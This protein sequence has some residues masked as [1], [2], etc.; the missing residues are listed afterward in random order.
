M[1]TA[2]SSRTAV[3]PERPAFFR[4]TMGGVEVALLAIY[5]VITLYPLIW[6]MISAFKTNADFA[7][8]FAL[9]AEWH[10]DNLRTA[11]TV[12]K[13]GTAMTNSVIVTSI[14]LALT[15]VLGALA[16][17]VLSR[18][19]FRFKALLMGF[20]LLGML[21]PI[22][23]TLVPLFILMN[24]VHLLNT[25]PAL[26]LPYFSFQ[27]PTAIFIATAYM[28]TFPKDIEE[29]AFVDGLGYWGIFR[30]IIL[31]LAS[32]ALAT[33]AILSVLRFWNEFSFALVFINKAALKTVPLSLSVFANGY[34]TD[35]KLTMA[36]MA[37]SV[38]PTILIYLFFSEKI[39]KGMTAGAVKG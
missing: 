26:I 19:Q 33:V 14:T 20:F 18:F 30:K 21:I 36:A 32:P 35:Y 17:Y 7:R 11:W 31:P 15:L 12:S 39:M 5:S 6:L 13:M 2:L 38:I 27:L 24:K 3:G 10:W 25:Y 9:P 23:S 4:K 34:A 22:H 16:A 28:G 1:K 8:P 37:I 29:A